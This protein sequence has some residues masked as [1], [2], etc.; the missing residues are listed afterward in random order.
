MVWRCA[1]WLSWHQ[2][3]GWLDAATLS[4]EKQN[5]RAI[6]F[7]SLTPAAI[8]VLLINET[9][10]GLAF[11]D[12]RLW[13]PSAHRS[14]LR[15]LTWTGRRRTC[16][17]AGERVDS[18]FGVKSTTILPYKQEACYFLL[19]CMPG[20]YRVGLFCALMLLIWSWFI[21][22]LLCHFCKKQQRLCANWPVATERTSTVL[23][24]IMGLKICLVSAVPARFL[25]WH[26]RIRRSSCFCSRTRMSSRRSVYS[27]ERR[28]R[29]FVFTV[30]AERWGRW[31]FWKQYQSLTTIKLL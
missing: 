12:L 17:L 26:F 2:L 6:T 7:T 1:V 10:C 4:K 19:G 11:S 27:S 3:S 21:K 9:V 15:C 25:L 20:L 22:L 16:C 13:A 8:K 14:G 5:K 28:R 29:I 30:K 31:S 23:S 18:Q 24:L